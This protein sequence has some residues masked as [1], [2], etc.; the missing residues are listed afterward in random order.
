MNLYFKNNLK[1]ELV[2]DLIFPQALNW[3]ATD[4]QNFISI[5][6]VD[7]LITISSFDVTYTV[8][9]PT[10]MRITLTPKGYIFIYNATFTFT[11]MPFNGTLHKAI[12]GYPFA[13]VNYATSKAISWFLIKA[14]ALSDMEKN[15][16]DSF[17]KFSNDALN[18][19]TLPFVQ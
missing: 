2:C 19:T 9:T 4:V 11:T 10:V 18:F 1:E 3:T 6:V 12:N 5:S 16:I 7:P 8:V 15:I 13:D 14:P 17:S